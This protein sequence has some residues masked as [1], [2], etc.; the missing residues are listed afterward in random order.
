[1]SLTQLYVPVLPGTGLLIPFGGMLTTGGLFALI[2]SS[3]PRGERFV[4]SFFGIRGVGSVYYLAYALNHGAFEDP[5]RLWGAV[6][7]VILISILLHGVTVTPV[8]AWL[9]RRRAA[10]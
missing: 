1:M 8:M 2:G 10:A 3:R 6:G 4:V 7:V 5:N 9:D